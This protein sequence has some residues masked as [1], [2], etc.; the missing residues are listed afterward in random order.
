MKNKISLENKTI[1]VTGSPGFIGAHLVLTLMKLL[2]LARIISFDNM[3]DYYDP[4]LK[5]YRLKK[6][7]K[8]SNDSTITHTFVSGN[9]Q[10]YEAV[11]S[12]FE[13]YHPEIVIN[14]AAQAGVRYSIEN[15]K[16]YIDSNI[17]GF[18]NIIE[19]CRRYPVEHLVFASSS[20]VYGGNAKIP[21][22]VEDKVYHPVSLYA[23]T[24]KS[25]ELL[26][27]SYSKL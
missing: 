17:I 2:K 18:Y 13:K 22:C 16:A 11:K 9:L 4:A 1:L 21:F 12:V 5:N 15:P 7:E 14:L 27:Y 8:R 26:A 10:D 3:N 25:Y 6:I 19:A 23:A 24:K 20:S